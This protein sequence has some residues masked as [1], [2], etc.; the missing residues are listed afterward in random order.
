MASIPARLTYKA[1]S[2]GV[3]VLVS[4]NVVEEFDQQKIRVP[5]FVVPL[6]F[7]ENSVVTTFFLVPFFGDC[8]HEPP[9]PPNQIIYSEYE[10]GQ[11]MENLYDP[12]WITGTLHTSTLTNELATSAYSVIVDGIFPYEY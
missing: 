1:L 11:M 8:T 12:V 2:T 3:P 9:P 5:G 7:N 10:P 6:E 4:T